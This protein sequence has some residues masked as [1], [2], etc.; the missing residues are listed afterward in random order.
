VA[1]E[2][3]KQAVV[4]LPQWERLVTAYVRETITRPFAFGEQ[5]CALWVCGAVD[6][7]CGT[8]LRAEFAGRYDDLAGANC[9]LRGRGW[10]TLLH[11]A[12]A[13]G[14]VPL[15]RAET[16][17][18]RKADLV[19]LPPGPSPEDLT[20]THGLVALIWGTGVMAPVRERVMTVPLSA[21]LRVGGTILKVG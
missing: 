9:L 19:F 2:V 8:A 15:T 11:A 17:R 12:L 16:Y 6:A 21:C 7:M 14:A 10:R 18:A 3:R 4:R 5:D 20:G 1:C 13:L